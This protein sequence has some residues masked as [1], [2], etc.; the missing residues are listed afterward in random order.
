M[1][2]LA[3][4]V[5]IFDEVQTIPINMIHMFNLALRFLVHT[6][7]ATVVL[8]TATQPPLDKLPNEYRKLTIEPEYK[9]IQNENELFEKFV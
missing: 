2:Q 1:H 7:G 6:C 5:I 3:N 4:S 8:C 9:I